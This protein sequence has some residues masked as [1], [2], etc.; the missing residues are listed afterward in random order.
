MPTIPQTHYN[1]TFAVTLFND[2]SVLVGPS[3]TWFKVV[4]LH[5]LTELAVVLEPSEKQEGNDAAYST[6]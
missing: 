6:N 1:W 5:G 2:I 3:V 4:G